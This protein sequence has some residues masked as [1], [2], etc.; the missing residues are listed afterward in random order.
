[1]LH[2]LAAA[3]AVPAEIRL[4]DHLFVKPDPDDGVP[5]ETCLVNLDPHSLRVVRGLVEPGVA[6][7]APGTRHQFE[8]L[9]TSA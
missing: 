5:G 8:R 1:M 7:A 6:A 4:Y 3:T 9:G 2:W